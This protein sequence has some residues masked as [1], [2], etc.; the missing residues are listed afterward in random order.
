MENEYRVVTPQYRV[1]TPQ[2]PVVTPQS[3]SVALSAKMLR[4]SKWYR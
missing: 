1:V 4:R 2:Y 3:T